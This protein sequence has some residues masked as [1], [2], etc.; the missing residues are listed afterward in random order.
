[1]ITI[2]QWR[3]IPGPPEAVFDR[4]TDHESWSDWAGTG[5]VT[6]V[7]EGQPDRNGLGA[8][9]QF[10]GGMQEEVTRFERGVAMD[11]RIIRGAGIKDHSGEVRFRAVPE[12]TEVTWRV[13][14]SPTIPFTGRLVKT[15][16]ERI[17]DRVLR[18]LEQQFQ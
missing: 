13:R 1:M 12:G 11:Y 3:T 18:S 14:C 7:R 6:L 4:Y 5:R 9:R 17:F 15:L 10:V 8:V 16:I 2:V